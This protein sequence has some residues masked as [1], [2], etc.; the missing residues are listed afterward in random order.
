MLNLRICSWTHLL[1][2]VT[3]WNYIGAYLLVLGP[4][5]CFYDHTSIGTYVAASP[6]SSGHPRSGA[7]IACRTSN[8]IIVFHIFVL[9]LRDVGSLPASSCTVIDNPNNNAKPLFKYQSSHH[10]KH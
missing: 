1:F 6:L 4:G 7:C 3:Q 8:L 2:V 5:S 9:A 10:L